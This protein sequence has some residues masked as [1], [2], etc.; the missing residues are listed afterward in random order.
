MRFIKLPVEIEAELLTQATQERIV[1]WIKS[2]S[3]RAVGS[4]HDGITI[5]TL[6]GMMRAEYGD[7]I[8]QGVVGEFYPCKPDVFEKTYEPA[9]NPT[10][11]RGR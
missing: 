7:W 2:Q 11:K 3:D 5:E 8:I 1:D 4:W 9:P 10:S 6:E